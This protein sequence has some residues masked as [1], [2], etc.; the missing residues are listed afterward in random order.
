M[1]PN[2]LKFYIFVDVFFQTAFLSHGAGTIACSPHARHLVF[3]KQQNEVKKKSRINRTKFL[4]T[5]T[6]FAKKSKNKHSASPT[7]K[8]ECVTKRFKILFY[9]VLKFTNITQLTDID[10]ERQPARSN[11]QIPDIFL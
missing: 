5:S 8:K 2:M 10:K 9:F 1:I 4:Q 3:A 11:K 6:S 7:L